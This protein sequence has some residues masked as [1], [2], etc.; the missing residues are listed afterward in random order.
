MTSNKDTDTLLLRC[1]Q[2]KDLLSIM[3]VSKYFYNLTSSKIFWI[4]RTKIRFGLINTENTEGKECY[5]YIKR[6]YPFKEWLTRENFKV[7]KTT[8]NSFQRVHDCEQ[9]SHTEDCVGC[10]LCL[11]VDYE[12]GYR[13]L[14]YCH[15]AKITKQNHF[16]MRYIHQFNVNEFRH[17]VFNYKKEEIEKILNL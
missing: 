14:G 8:K 13:F 3:R 4:N 11:Y 10:E 15:A 9:M 12:I 16:D 17:K 1:L 5:K 2:D 6:I 7:S